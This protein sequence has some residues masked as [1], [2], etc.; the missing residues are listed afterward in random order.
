MT[1]QMTPQSRKVDPEEIRR[2]TEEML[3][4]N[5]VDVL[6]WLKAERNLESAL[7]SEAFAV[8]DKVKANHHDARCDKLAKV[9]REVEDL[10]TRRD[11]FSV[12][13]QSKIMLAL[14]E[15][16]K[17]VW[18]ATHRHYKG[19][20][21]RVTGTRMDARGEELIEGIDYD[22]AAGNKYFLDRERW[23]SHV[24]SGRLR[25]EPLLPR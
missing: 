23:E 18:S 4:A 12:I 5:P 8:D 17:P 14:S 19:T 2:D 20:L 22:D 24:P 10:R 6:T 13:L 1:E 11:A 25:Y 16:Q 3:E 21:Y 7:R 15:A 9:I